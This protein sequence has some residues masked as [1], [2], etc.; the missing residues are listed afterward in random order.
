MFRK[1]RFYFVIVLS[2]MARLI[3]SF[4]SG[5]IEKLYDKLQHV[6]VYGEAC[7]KQPTKERKRKASE[8]IKLLYRNVGQYKKFGTF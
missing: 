5:N 6:H 4:R 2:H 1:E 3:H 8:E 7:F